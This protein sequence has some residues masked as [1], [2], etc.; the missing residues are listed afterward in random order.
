MPPK[1]QSSPLSCSNAD[2]KS[3]ISGEIVSRKTPD[4]LSSQPT[5]PKNNATSE[6]TAPNKAPAAL[7]AD[8]STFAKE[9]A[10][11]T[12]VD[13]AASAYASAFADNF[14]K[15]S[16]VGAASKAGNAALDA[17][18][19]SLLESG[20]AALDAVSAPAESA[21]H[22]THFPGAVSSVYSELHGTTNE[23]SVVANAINTDVDSLTVSE[24]PLLGDMAL[25]PDEID[26]IAAS[27]KSNDFKSDEPNKEAA[28]VHSGAS[29]SDSN[30]EAAATGD[31]LDSSEISSTYKARL[32]D[33]LDV[34]G[35][36]SL[37]SSEQSD[38]D[39]EQFSVYK[40]EDDEG[41]IH[42]DDV[43]HHAAHDADSAHGAHSAT[44]HDVS[45]AQGAAS[46]ERAAS[47]VSEDAAD[48]VVSP[49][50]LMVDDGSGLCD[51]GRHQKHAHRGPHKCTCGK[52]DKV[53]SASDSSMELNEVVDDGSGGDTI[54][55][56]SQFAH[57]HD[58]GAAIAEEASSPKPMQDGT[59]AETA[60]RAKCNVADSAADA[61]VSQALAVD[62]DAAASA[63]T[64]SAATAA[65]GCAGEADASGER[66]ESGAQASLVVEHKRGFW[67]RLRFKY[68]RR[69][70]RI[71]YLDTLGDYCGSYAECR[72]DRAKYFPEQEPYLESTKGCRFLHQHMVKTEFHCCQ[73]CKS[74]H[75]LTCNGK[76]DEALEHQLMAEEL[77]LPPSL[78]HLQRSGQGKDFD[79]YQGLP[80]IKAKITTEGL[81][82]NAIK[83]QSGTSAL[84]VVNATHKDSAKN[85]EKSAEAAATVLTLEEDA[86]KS[87]ALADASAAA[88]AAAA[89]HY[90]TVEGTLAHKDD[91][92]SASSAASAAAAAMAAASAV[93][94]GTGAAGAGTGAVAAA[95]APKDGASGV[96][97]DGAVHGDLSQGE[98]VY[99][100][101]AL[102]SKVL[103]DKTTRETKRV[104]ERALDYYN[105]EPQMV[106]HEVDVVEAKRQAQELQN[107]LDGESN[108][109]SDRSN[110]L[111]DSKM[112]CRDSE[113]RVY[114]MAD[115]DAKSRIALGW[116][117]WWQSFGLLIFFFLHYARLRKFLG[118]PL[119]SGL[120][121]FNR[122]AFSS[123]DRPARMVRLGFY[124]MVAFV[125]CLALLM[126][127]CSS[128]Q[129][130]IPHE[131]VVKDPV[132]FEIEG[133]QGD[134][135][136]NV[137]AHIDS[138]AV[139]SK[140]RV[141]FYAR[142]ISDTATKA[143][144][145]YGYY[146]PVI[147]VNLPKKDDPNDTTVVINIDAGKP[148]Y[149]RNYSVEILGEGS[150]YKAFQDIKNNSQIASYKILDHGLYEKL[151]SSIHETALSLGFFDGKYISSR[152]MVYQD[153]NA[154]DIELIYDSGKRYSFGDLLTDEK[155]DK[156]L[157]PVRSLK[158]FKKGEPFSSK[159]VN[160][161][162]QALTQTNYYGSVDVR[163]AIDKL[164]DYQVPLEVHLEPRAAN[165]IRVGGGYSTDEGIRV[166]LEW[167]KPLLNDRG[168][169]FNSLMTLT[170]VTQN[171]SF[172]YKIPHENPN[173][174]YFTLNA[175][176]LH[177]ELNDTISDRS[178][179]AFHYIADQTGRWR[180]DYALR[181]EYE[182][183]DQAS[184]TGYAFNTIP[185]LRLLRRESSG[186][187]DPEKGYSLTLE[188]LG[189]SSLFGD[190]SFLQVH[191]VYKGI[192]S[193]GSNYRLFVRA[194][195]GANFGPD[196]DNVPPSLRF[197]AGGDNSIRGFGYRDISTYQPDGS[198]LKGAKYLTTGSIEYQFP[199]GIASSR[200]AVFLDG[201]IATDDYT[202]NDISWGPG[203]GYRFLSAYGT[204][205]VDFAVGI[206]GNDERKYQLHFAFGPEF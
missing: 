13:D 2:P 145:A 187:F 29:A 51:C 84:A 34:V 183:Y 44:A 54:S 85:L 62:Q 174:D 66:S 70:V 141:R 20:A 115:V 184:E 31:S 58:D 108:A 94:A 8:A 12:V 110:D 53:R 92:A 176:Q 99:D 199:I 22:V 77:G 95:D 41:L 155:T 170:Q 30:R 24:A 162:V 127:G 119:V 185:H 130:E 201:G 40:S 5:A 28:N 68:L 60:E 47:V 181:F 38:F 118:L 173:N 164:H 26:A 139:I 167:N 81:D 138:L 100:V 88:F 160:D 159:R 117:H 190:D 121:K 3:T 206:H 7:S 128:S 90:V 193:V 11:A 143:L 21:A 14:A 156:L 96:A 9:M 133:V 203:I 135:L 64:A 103:H 82:I 161:Y 91:A 98:V 131:Q 152:I 6:S 1:S 196:A 169:S 116:G 179:F 125:V 175:S 123:P 144:R 87:S 168:D 171:A 113:T 97:F 71:V 23:E 43:S 101:A 72:K 140:S 15:S 37:E 93:G 63:E 74:K 191:G 194:E 197:F 126:S 16:E 195:Q 150:E 154:A 56:T 149:I 106:Y 129:D 112:T 122:F 180:R 166:L 57:T 107:G 146:N 79:A 104:I 42:P 200:G 172:I 61:A 188:T 39:L 202:N 157:V 73:Y 148:L 192:I 189:S 83:A 137:Q 27:L 65:A 76:E 178:Q 198:G 147:H 136:T 32:A 69:A 17:N 78:G 105:R 111:L 205:R 33:A 50:S 177:T 59:A 120:I 134:L 80:L 158:E 124:C 52:H 49:H 165:N 182:D 35:A 151:K 18:A 48:E 4:T 55:F 25:S 163:P 153:Q 75:K 204:V 86:V 36:P 186:G 102:H 45:G 19:K 109:L 46:S 67:A 89:G 132:S 10:A 114:L 142:E